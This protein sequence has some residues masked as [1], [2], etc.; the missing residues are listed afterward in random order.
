MELNI[1]VA[2]CSKHAIKF[3]FFIL[4]FSYVS[5]CYICKTNHLKFEINHEKERGN[6]YVC[7]S[8][9]ELLKLP[10]A[11]KSNLY[12]KNNE[13]RIAIS[14]LPALKMWIIYFGRHGNVIFFFRNRTLSLI[15]S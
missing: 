5:F 4:G 1:S 12:L 9:T 2:R 14:I 7:V 15:G 6:L 3:T 13:T 10:I 8:N 11:V